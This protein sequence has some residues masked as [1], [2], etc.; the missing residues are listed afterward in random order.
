MA[1]KELQVNTR[2]LICPPDHHIPLTSPRASPI[3]HPEFPPE[4]KLCQIPA[5]IG[6]DDKLPDRIDDT[7]REMPRSKMRH[8]ELR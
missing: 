8:A 3:N 7:S 6:R 2:T 5:E 4:R 1:G